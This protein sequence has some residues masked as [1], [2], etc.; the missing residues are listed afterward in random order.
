MKWTAGM[1]IVTGLLY[2]ALWNRFSQN[3]PASKRLFTTQVHFVRQ[4]TS[5]EVRTY[6]TALRNTMIVLY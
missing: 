5:R 2:A 3:T 4:S 1:N 6:K